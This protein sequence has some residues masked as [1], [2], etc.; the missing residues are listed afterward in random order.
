MQWVGQADH[1]FARPK[2]PQPVMAAGF[3]VVAGLI[4]VSA[5]LRL[6]GDGHF[7]G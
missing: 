3:F 2:T 5:F 7:D 6:G 4:C 1:L